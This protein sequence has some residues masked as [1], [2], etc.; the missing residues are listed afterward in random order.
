MAGAGEQFDQLFAA[1]RRAENERIA[2]WAALHR[3]LSA[4]AHG[5][6]QELPTAQELQALDEAKRISAEADQ[7]M[8]DFG[9]EHCGVH[10]K[11]LYRTD[12]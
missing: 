8:R 4:I 1:Y 11:E 10:W 12:P 3:K 7:A 5:K 6:S 2:A 9:A